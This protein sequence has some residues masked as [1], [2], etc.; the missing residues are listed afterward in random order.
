MPGLNYDNHT[1]PAFKST[2]LVFLVM[3][4]HEFHMPRWI[5]YVHSCV[6]LDGEHDSLPSRI[7]ASVYSFQ[8]IFLK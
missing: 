8:I 5:S 7:L 4:F 3:H 6:Y 1:T 2:P